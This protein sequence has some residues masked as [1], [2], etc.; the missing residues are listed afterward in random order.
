MNLTQQTQTPTP[1]WQLCMTHQV[2]HFVN[3]AQTCL[4]DKISKQIGLY[5]GK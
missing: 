1:I 4:H 3:V 5:V 2:V